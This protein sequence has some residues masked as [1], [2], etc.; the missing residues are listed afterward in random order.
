M[1][2][3]EG[4]ILGWQKGELEQGGG[5]DRIKIRCLHV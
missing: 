1:E 3:G 4:S 2:Y 5:V